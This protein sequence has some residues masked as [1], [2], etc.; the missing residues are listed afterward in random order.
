[1]RVRHEGKVFKEVFSVKE[2]AELRLAIGWRDLPEA[3]ADEI[4]RSDFFF[5]GF[6]VAAQVLGERVGHYFVHV[7]ADALHSGLLRYRDQGTVV[8]SLYSLPKG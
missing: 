8:N 4:V 5:E 2:G 7:D 1:L 6:V 3:F